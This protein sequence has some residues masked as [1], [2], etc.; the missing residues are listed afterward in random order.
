MI[1]SL[2][3][4]QVIISRFNEVTPLSSAWTPLPTITLT[5][6]LI[7]TAQPSPTEQTSIAVSPTNQADPKSICVHTVTYWAIHPELWPEQVNIVGFIYKKEMMTELFNTQ[8]WDLPAELFAQLHAAYLNT[9][10]GEE[11][12]IV[13][14]AIVDTAN[15]LSV[16]LAD[17]EISEAD[18]QTG[19][20]LGT[21]L[22]DYNNGRLR[23]G[24]CDNNPAPMQIDEVFLPTAVASPT[25]VIPTL[26][27]A[28]ARTPVRLP[29]FTPTPGKPRPRE[30]THSTATASPIKIPTDTPAAPPSPIPTQIPPPTPPTQI[31]LP[32]PAPALY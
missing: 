4:S 5:V 25:T 18:L 7:R 13:T 32:T 22:A 8:S 15:W 12:E 29:T 14:Q 17:S 23:H 30:R 26:M 31:P 3:I 21:I 10:N 28:P 1:I 19:F 24:L 27:V 6:T 11:I 20:S 9:F 2:I 16:H